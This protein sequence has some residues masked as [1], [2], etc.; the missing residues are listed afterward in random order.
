[1]VLRILGLLTSI[2]FL[3]GCNSDVRFGSDHDANGKAGCTPVTSVSKAFAFPEALDPV[4]VACDGDKECAVICHVPRGN[5][6]AQHTIVVG[7]PALRAHITHNHNRSEDAEHRDYLGECVPRNPGGGGG[8]GDDDDDDDD[9]GG[10][11]GGGGNGGNHPPNGDDDD[12]DD[13]DGGSGGGGNGGNQP[14]NG[15]DDD[16]D[17]DDGGGTPGGGSGGGTPGG[18]SGGG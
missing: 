10:G 2:A 11:S 17:D 8:S 12:D 6:D 18:G 5:P 15:D 4:V 13:D 9:D 1:M 14:P 3:I 16:D 7:L